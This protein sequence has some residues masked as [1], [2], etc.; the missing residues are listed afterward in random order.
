MSTS[1][2]KFGLHDFLNAQPLLLPLLRQEK[3]LGVK[4]VK[5][6]PAR[7][8]EQLL[9]SELDLAMIPAIEFLLHLDRY[10]LLPGVCIASRGEVKT[11]LL[12]AKVPLKNIKTLAVDPRS[13]TS[14]ALLKLLFA[15]QFSSTNQFLSASPDPSNML[16]D[17]DAALII[18]DQA[19][20]A[21]LLDSVKFAFDLSEEWFQR[22]GKTFVHAV[23]VAQKN[24]ELENQ[25]LD[26]LL[27][28]GAKASDEIDAI[29]KNHSERLGLE[30]NLC[31][32]YLQN[33][34]IYSLGEEELQ[35]LKVF[36]KMCYEKG[37]VDTLAPFL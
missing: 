28:A 34:I 9:A 35:G 17:H 19:M 5:D 1:L 22:T 8:A 20:G 11:V 13:K 29:A 24:I 26:Y 2:I 18:G 4:I 10:R 33:K 31:R 37:L 14:V 15:D 12:V 23:V 27:Q 32:D 7:L 3:I 25:L 36:Q 6:V 21:E 30:E 16:Q